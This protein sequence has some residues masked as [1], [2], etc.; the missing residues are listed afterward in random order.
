MDNVH[1]AMESSG[2]Q[3]VPSKYNEY[4]LGLEKQTST[5]K[6]VTLLC[7]DFSHRRTSV[8]FL[9]TTTLDIGLDYHVRS[10]VTFSRKTNLAPT[11]H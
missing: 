6:Q 3:F 11:Y 10:A 2:N 7:R 1:V 9:I 8:L 5:Y 4:K